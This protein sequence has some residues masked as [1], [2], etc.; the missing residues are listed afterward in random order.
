MTD[1]EA[2]AQDV[3]LSY[4]EPPDE[5][6]FVSATDA[7]KIAKV[8]AAEHNYTYTTDLDAMMDFVVVHWCD[9]PL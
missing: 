4:V 9:Y 1:T 8:I 6:W 3:L 2:L 7:V 5:I